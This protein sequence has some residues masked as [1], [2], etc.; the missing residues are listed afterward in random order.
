MDNPISKNKQKSLGLVLS[1]GGARGLAHIAVLKALEKENVMIS[2]ISGCSMGGLI[3]ALYALGLPISQIE[4]VAKKYSSIREM[5]K[6]VDPTPR[7]RGLIV[8]KRVRNFLE[9]LIGE[10]V[11]IC[12]TK[13]PLFLNAVDLTT[14][15]E[16]ILETGNLLDAV[17]ATSAVPGFFAPVHFGE[18]QL[19]DG[20]VL[21]NLPVKP[22][23]NANLQFILGVNVHTDVI[24][25]PPSKYLYQ[26]PHFPIPLPDFFLDYYRAELIMVSELNARNIR[27]YPPDLLIK[28][29]IS[30]D[31]TIFLGFQRIDE[32]IS[33]GESII[34]QHLEEINDLIF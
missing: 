30:P 17:M 16:I 1:G 20:G 15:K 27:D 4:K 12:D 11:D 3:G 8:G 14:L 5:I 7:R 29:L 32:I 25:E 26:H 18:Y 6:L 19:I 24:S 23:I 2:A 10:D 31:I 13:I 33:A 9:D 21:D 28:P 22:L 34:L